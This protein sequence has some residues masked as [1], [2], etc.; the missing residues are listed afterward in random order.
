MAN[1]AVFGFY[2]GY[3]SV[4]SSVDALREAGFRNTD[5]SVLFPQQAGSQ[6]LAHEKDAKAPEGAA[7]GV[8]TGAVVGGALGWLAGIGV[9]AIPGLG[10]FNAAG[11]IAAALE[12]MGV[13]VGGAVGGLTG[14]M[15]GLGIPELQAKQYEDRVKGGGILLSVHSDDIEWTK[16]AKK[17]LEQTGAQDISSTTTGAEHISSTTGPYKDD[18][19]KALEQADLKDVTVDED[20]AQ[21]L[22]TLGGTLHS[23][24][25]KA[26]AGDIAQTAAG[27]GTVANEISIQPVGLESEAKSI[28]SNL[29]D[30]IESNFKA[31]LTSNSLHKQDIRFD[32]KNGVLTLKGTVDIAEQRQQAQQLAAHV[33]NVQQVVNEIEVGR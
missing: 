30:G 3:S 28:A 19:Q 6:D 31:A 23:H 1:T 25:A 27:N 15:I 12:T 7:A 2:P 4:E 11:P 8:T 22:V 29:D 18:V 17:I 10:F 16:R 9:R 20:C 13:A 33:P 21:N 32:V 14:A 5:I 24:E 26:K